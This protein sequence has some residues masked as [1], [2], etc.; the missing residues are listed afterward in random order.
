MTKDTDLFASA[1]FLA[2]YV[3]VENGKL[4]SSGAFWNRLNLP[5]FPSVT[6]FGVAIVLTIPWR[7]Y[8]QVHKFAVWF[9]DA[10]G[11][12]LAGDIQGEFA[13]D[14][15]PDAQVGEPTIMPITAMVG[16]FL[17][18]S[19]GNYSAVLHVDGQELDRWP[20]RAIQIYTQTPPQL[21]TPMAAG[22]ED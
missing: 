1:F 10:D 9:E 3:T 15:S 19:A 13:V 5:S 22:K 21:N 8:R 18:P 11:K 7:A 17:I 6:N 20:F 14:A 4:Y 12:Q 2:D 16:N